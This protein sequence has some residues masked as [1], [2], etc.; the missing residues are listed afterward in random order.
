MPQDTPLDHTSL[1]D[2]T[3]TLIGRLID[4][5]ATPQDQEAFEQ[6]AD[7]ETMLWRTMALRQLDMTMLSERVRDRTDVAERIEVTPNPRRRLNVPLMLSGWAA[8]LMLGLWWAVAAGPGEGGGRALLEPVV[9]PDLARERELTPDE[10]LDRYLQA[11]FVL[12]ELDPHLLDQEPLGGGRHRLRI[13]RRIEEFIEI[14]TPPEA[15]IDDDTGKLKRSPA[16][17]RKTDS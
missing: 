16:E 13:M 6:M 14:S 1:P 10:H 4:G 15:I 7:R 8:V 2:E 9:A 17:L 5:E 3:E 12:G 11:D